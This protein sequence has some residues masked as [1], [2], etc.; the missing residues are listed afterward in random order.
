MR[1]MPGNPVTSSIRRIRSD[2]RGTASATSL[3]GVA[4]VLMIVLC[5]FAAASLVQQADGDGGYAADV[6]EP[7]LTAAISSLMIQDIL[8]PNASAGNDVE[9]PV[10]AIVTLDASDSVDD[11]GVA[12]YTWTFYDGGIRTLYGDVVTH[13][14]TAPGVYDITLN[15]S[16]AEGN[17]DIDYVT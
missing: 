8:P 2:L 9:V 3:A 16:D 15:T 11:R 13:V 14:F 7:P 1:N 17:W 6:E 4:V 12:N 5:S 10:G